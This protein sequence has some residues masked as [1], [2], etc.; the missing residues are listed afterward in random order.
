[1]TQHIHFSPEKMALV[2]AHRTLDTM[3]DAELD[4]WDVYSDAL[5]SGNPALVEAAVE[6]LEQ[7]TTHLNAAIINYADALNAYR[8]FWETQHITCSPLTA[9]SNKLRLPA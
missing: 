6:R 5:A 9:E 3:R 2:K 1:M 7:A 8:A 4:A